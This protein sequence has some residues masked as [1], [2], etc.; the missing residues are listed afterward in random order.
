[1][2]AAQMPCKSCSLQLRAP[3]PAPAHA[4]AAL[5]PPP[6]PPPQFAASFLFVVLYI[7]GTYSAPPASSFRYKLDV[8]LCAYFALEYLHRFLVGWAGGRVVQGGCGRGGL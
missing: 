6:P 8:G 2:L 4:P 1:M 7:W 5:P 3:P